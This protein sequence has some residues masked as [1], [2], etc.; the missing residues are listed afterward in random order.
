ML[1]I[2]L[3]PILMR[4]LDFLTNFKNYTLGFVAYMAMMPVFTM[5]FQI[6]AMSNLHDISWGNRP[7]L[8]GQSAFTSNRNDAIKAEGDY[9]MFRTNFVLFWLT[10]NTVYYIVITLTVNSSVD[11]K[12]HDSDSEYLAYFAIYLAALVIFRVLFALIYICK[13]KMRYNCCKS[14]KVVP[15]N[16]REDVKGRKEK[17]EPVEEFDKSDVEKVN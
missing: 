10:V 4:P 17:A 7:S 12:L 11:S 9:K 1:S 5:V 6:Y 8:T 2:Y 14:Y 16:P 3:M 15:L 13:W